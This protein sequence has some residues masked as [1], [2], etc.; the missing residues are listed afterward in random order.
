MASNDTTVLKRSPLTVLTTVPVREWLV[1]YPRAGI[2]FDELDD[3]GSKGPIRHSGCC[4]EVPICPNQSI[5]EPRS[6]G[7][8]NLKRIQTGF[9]I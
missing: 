6:K 8:I 3:R 5:N 7:M 9:S 4:P 1:I 2:F